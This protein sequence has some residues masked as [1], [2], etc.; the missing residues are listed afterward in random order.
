[1][2]SH[3]RGIIE[4]IGADRAVVEANGV[5]YELL[6]SRT[7]LSKLAVGKSAKLFA[8]LN[9]SQDAIALYGFHSDE[10]RAMFRKL[11]GVTRIGPK[12]ALAALSVLSPEDIALAVLTD[13]AAAFDGV[14]GLGRKT[15]ARIILELKEKVEGVGAGGAK[16]SA[17]DA[18][19]GDAGMRHEA[20]EALVALGYDGASAGRA[21]ASVEGCTRVEDM[22][23]QALR[24]LAGK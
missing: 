7:T 21:V 23:M 8:H 9:I 16:P 14:P 10:E 17:N 3:I 5:G 6:C 15:A 18:K 22:I 12:V 24:S 13:N 19:S 4:E 2:Y 11:I 20:I 1:M